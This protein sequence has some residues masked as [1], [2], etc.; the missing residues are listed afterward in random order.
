MIGGW[1]GRGGGFSAFVRQHKDDFIVILHGVVTIMLRFRDYDGALQT[2]ACQCIHRIRGRC[3]GE[4]R[5]EA[6][7]GVPVQ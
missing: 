7:D 1:T 6:R 3:H 2:E 4:W 5:R